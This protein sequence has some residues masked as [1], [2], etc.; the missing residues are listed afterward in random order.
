M[1]SFF[2]SLFFGLTEKNVEGNRQL[3]P[4][5]DND[6]VILNNENGKFNV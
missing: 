4:I 1:D 5:E 3:I 6:D 2:Y